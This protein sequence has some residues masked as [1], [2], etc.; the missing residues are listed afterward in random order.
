MDDLDF[1]GLR[2]FIAGA[3]LDTEGWGFHAEQL[4]LRLNREA[5]A[6][7]GEE[8]GLGV[9]VRHPMGPARHQCRG[10]DEH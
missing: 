3:A 2:I 4:H 5:V 8:G 7:I 10:D 1:C 9:I 6:V